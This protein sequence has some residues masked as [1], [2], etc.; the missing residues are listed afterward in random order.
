MLPIQRGRFR[1]VGR[2]RRLEGATHVGDL[3]PA[4]LAT[5]EMERARRRQQSIGS[6]DEL[7]RRQMVHDSSFF[8]LL[9]A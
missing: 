6:V 1:H 5:L 3:R 4:A 7:S 9:S 8:R 2:L